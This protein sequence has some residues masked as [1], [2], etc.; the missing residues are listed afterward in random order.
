MSAVKKYL[1]L[2]SENLTKRYICNR[3]KIYIIYAVIFIN[4]LFNFILK[5]IYVIQKNKYKK[6]YKLIMF[7]N[8]LRRFP[9]NDYSYRF[10]PC[11]V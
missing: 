11:G 10:R 4:I 2:I 6:F 1:L 9:V 3:I 7:I 5:Y 8:K